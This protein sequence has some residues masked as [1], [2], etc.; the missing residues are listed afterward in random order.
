[1][2]Q[3]HHRIP[4]FKGETIGP[5][6]SRF[7]DARAVWNGTIDRRP[8]L[9]ARCTENS[10]IVS[11]ISYAR[12]AN[13]PIAVRCGGH[14]LAGYG[15]VDGGLVLDLSPMNKVE[16]DA[17]GRIARVQGGC[18]LGDVDRA[19]QAHGLATPAGVV[20]DTGA[21]G[22]I[23]GGG[24]GWQHR[25]HGLSVDNMVGAEVILANGEVVRANATEHPDLFWALRG[26]G[27][28]FG[29]VSEF[30]M[31]LHSRGPVL[32]AMIAVPLKEAVNALRRWR[33][34]MSTAPDDLVWNCFF[35]CLKPF[36]WVP[37]GR[38]GEWALVMPI[39]WLGD[40]SEG[41]PF[42]NAITEQFAGVAIVQMETVMPFLALQTMADEAIDRGAM[43]YHKSGFI[44][45]F[46]DSMIAI[47]AAQIS[48]APSALTILELIA[49]GGAVARV[50][51]EGTAFAHRD[52]K[53]TI[54]FLGIWTKQ[55]PSTP[56]IEWVR[57]T[58]QLLEPHMNG[59]FYVNFGGAEEAEAHSTPS[60]A[61]GATWDRLRQIK[62]RYDPEN[63]F[64]VNANIP[65]IT[66]K[67]SAKKV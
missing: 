30:Q 3:P 6:D 52:A 25:K 26:G 67:A 41:R 1:M 50:P 27:G 46:A 62:T 48:R 16:V 66:A 7:D 38:V 61:Y 42:L 19:T 12:Q 56:N 49:M 45:D 34:Y 37:P 23:L 53:W 9:I 22:L 39:L 44:S 35:Q 40:H 36:P 63:V 15:V 29:V 4:G 32:V 65:P 20:S 10:D 51:P 47:L 57:K 18:L 28:N 13:L 21:G 11:A 60:S 58:Y 55:E 33:D 31:R 14:S 17:E 8:A 54:N 5:D 43:H 24:I 64:H 59:R 2:S